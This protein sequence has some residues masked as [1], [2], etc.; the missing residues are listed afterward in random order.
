MKNMKI[1]EPSMCCPTGLC[2]VSFDP[3]L[4]RISAIFDKLAKSDVKV[5]RF[6]LTNSPMEFIK[7]REVNKIVGD[8]GVEALPITIVEGEIVL[9]GRYPKNEEIMKLLDLPQELFYEV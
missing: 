3:E 9:M 8:Q 5:E 6:N 4:V 1:Y 2:G 7:N